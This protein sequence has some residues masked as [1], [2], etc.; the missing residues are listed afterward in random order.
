M[1]ELTLSGTDT[2]AADVLP[3]LDLEGAAAEEV[4]E[5]AE[6][7]IQPGA[8]N[9]APDDEKPKAD[10]K[11]ARFPKLGKPL[12][13]ET[14]KL[15]RD[16]K[17]AQP[18]A[19]KEIMER[20]WQQENQ[21][22][23]IAEH[24]PEK[25]LDEAIQLKADAGAQR[26]LL[27]NHEFKTV[28]EAMNEVAE[29]RGIDKKIIAGDAS[30]IKDLPEEI[31]GGL[32]GQMPDI[33]GEWAARDFDGYNRYFSGV[34]IKTVQNSEAFFDMK[35]VLR[36]LTKAGDLSGDP[37]LLA[38]K[39]AIQGMLGLFEKI[40]K[41]ASTAAVPKAKP[42]ADKGLKDRE[43]SIRAREIQATN[44][45][46][47]TRTLRYVA[48]PVGQTLIRLLGKD[49]STKVNVREVLNKA[50]GFMSEAVGKE[51]DDDLK[52]FAEGGDVEGAERHTKSKLTNKIITEATEK[53]YKLIYRGAT[54][55]SGKPAPKA[56][57]AP[58][59]K[60][61]PPRADA[62]SDYKLQATRPEDHRIDLA[63]TK[64]AAAKEGKNF[65]QFITSG[66]AVLKGGA[67]VRWAR[68]DME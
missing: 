52:R 60:Q 28:Q 58:G 38:A 67:K 15:L 18:G 11:E 50:L 64:A 37:D 13:A 33:I 31:A 57:G 1:D 56:N 55:G 22:K 4:Q 54:F 35:G 32:L 3:G 65:S 2:G 40:G 63:A 16:M 25:G 5:G 61:P 49:Y 12:K 39:E 47:S 36:T 8:E 10:P 30:F 21:T 26:D 9:D 20:V 53:A 48:G 42:E 24:F 66:R 41:T 27:R 62:P 34:F 45:D 68:P 19:Y 17:E 59:G 23:K 29:Y 14:A 43:T 6:P 44:N 7:E 51:Y 46:I